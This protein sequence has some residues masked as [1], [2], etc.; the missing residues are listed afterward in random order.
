MNG[1]GKYKES[2][3]VRHPW[4][5]LTNININPTIICFRCMINQ[6]RGIFVFLASVTRKEMIKIMKKNPK[7]A[8][9]SKKI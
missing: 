3:L 2:C 1:E 7:I 5:I 9:D 6:Y 8:K 4:D